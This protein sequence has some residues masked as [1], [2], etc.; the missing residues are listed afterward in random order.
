MAKTPIM[1]KLKNRINKIHKVVKIN[2]VNGAFWIIPS[3]FTLKRGSWVSR[4]F[5]TIEDLIMIVGLDNSSQIISINKDPN[6]IHFNAVQKALE[7]EMFIPKVFSQKEF[8]FN[9]IANL[10]LIFDYKSLSAIYDGFIPCFNL[11][12]YQ[13][14]ASSEPNHKK[15]L[16][17]TKRGFIEKT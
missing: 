13:K 11:Y 15:I 12:Y 7:I 1:D 5:H 17:W 6:F 4:P 16:Y 9:F 14:L 8:R 2:Y 10:E 3:I